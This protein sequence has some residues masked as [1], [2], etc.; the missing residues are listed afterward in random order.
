MAHSFDFMDPQFREK[1][2]TNN[3]AMIPLIFADMDRFILSIIVHKNHHDV[4][5]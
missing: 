5:D 2:S 1:K 4:F 3:K